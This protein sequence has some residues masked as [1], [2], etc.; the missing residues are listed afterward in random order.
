MFK[1]DFNNLMILAGLRYERTDVDYQGIKIITERGKYSSMDSLFAKR[2]TEFLLP[3][4]HLKYS[5]N[6]N[7]NLRI[8]Y[9]ETYARPNFE[10]VIPYREQDR[11]E[12][13]YGN[14]DLKFPKAL[15]I[16]FLGEYYGI[17]KINLS[18]GLFFKQIDDFIFYFKRFA[19]EGKDFS[20]YGIVQIEKAVNGLRAKV[21]GAE[22]Q[23][24]F[25]FFFFD[26]FISN[27]GMFLNYTYTNSDAY[28]GKRLSAN[29][30]EA[31]VIFGQDDLSIYSSTTE[32][33]KISL[34]GQSKH[35]ANAAFYYDDGIFYCKLSAN[36]HDSFLYKLGADKDL[37]EY[38]QESIHFDMTASYRINDNFKIFVDAINLTN[39]PLKFY[40]GSRDY[41]LQ[42]EFYSWWGRIG[43]RMSF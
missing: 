27:F 42:Q 31:V 35:A 43:F 7:T 36:Y 24:Q 34:P 26:G 15:N 18:G 19:H 28:I 17:N 1:H 6:E 38:Y 37:D 30:T 12:V 10:D 8:A 16:D 40:L 5:L 2:S 22:L 32:Q 39:E 23:A 41:P 25:N 13:K 14:P 33:E 20:N 3:Q 4:I 21:Y 11:E 9:T 29:Y